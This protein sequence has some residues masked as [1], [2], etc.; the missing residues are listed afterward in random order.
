MTTT[1]NVN[2]AS[3]PINGITND[4]ILKFAGK[5]NTTGYKVVIDESADGF[6]GDVEILGPNVTKSFTGIE[7]FAFENFINGGARNND[8]VDATRVSSG[9]TLDTGIGDDT[10]D[11]GA[12]DDTFVI[13]NKRHGHDVVDGGAGHDTLDL[14]SGVGG[15]LAGQYTISGTNIH[16]TKKLVAQS[17]NQPGNSVSFSNFEVIKAG[18]LADVFTGGYAARSLKT[19]DM[20]NGDDVFGWLVFDGDDLNID[21]GSRDDLVKIGANPGSGFSGLLNGTVQGGMGRDTLQIGTTNGNQGATGFN[22]VIADDAAE[23]NAFAG[24]VEYKDVADG[25]VADFSGFETITFSTFKNAKNVN[26][27]VD[28][29]GA[30]DLTLDTGAGDDTVD[31][32]TGNDTFV[33][34]SKGFGADV[35]DGGAGHDTLDLSAVTGAG[36]ADFSFVGVGTFANSTIPL[37]VFAN[38]SNNIAFDNFEAIISGGGNDVFGGRVAETTTGNAFADETLKYIDMGAGND[39]FAWNYTGGTLDIDGGRG[40][41]TF[42]LGETAGNGRV[43]LLNGAIDGGVGTDELLF[44]LVNAANGDGFKVIFD[45]DGSGGVAYRDSVADAATGVPGLIADLPNFVGITEFESIET[46]A[47]E[48][49]DRFG[50]NDVVDISASQTN[51]TIDTGAGDDVIVFGNGGKDHVTGGAGADTFIFEKDGWFGKDTITDFDVNEDSL[52]GLQGVDAGDIKLLKDGDTV[53]I[54]ADNG[55]LLLEGL[56]VDEVSSLFDFGMA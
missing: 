28:A 6:F 56:T 33:I 20:A 39:L 44:G 48:A 50:T 29:T 24:T 26:D 55:I 21:A 43:S 5:P 35:V 23:S 53:Q 1:I 4:D 36:R 49:D 18:T 22:V 27:H 32:G 15:N 37:Q 3:S 38:G 46:L 10:V 30:T 47:F 31:F 2:D 13:G 16:D 9:L 14:L 45:G 8:I 42:E 52:I 34:G 51:L 12:G 19:I 54:R 7:G 11:F 17:V 25:P 40:N 41:D